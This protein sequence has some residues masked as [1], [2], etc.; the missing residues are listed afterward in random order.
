MQ[1]TRPN[2]YLD[3]DGVLLGKGDLASP[4]LQVH[5]SPDLT[6]LLFLVDYLLLPTPLRVSGGG[7]PLGIAGWSAS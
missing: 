2:L 1:P 4:K 3:V 7:K 5:G 6:N